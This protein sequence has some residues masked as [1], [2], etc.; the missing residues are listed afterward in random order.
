MALPQFQHFHLPDERLIQY[1]DGELA[2]V[3]REQARTHLE[4]CWKCR[5]RGLELEKAIAG[6]VRVQER[7]LTQAP[8]GGFAMGMAICACVALGL[9]LWLARTGL[10]RH[11]SFAVVSRPVSALTPGAALLVDR[12]AVC[13]ETNP[14]NRAV[15]VALQRKVF[16]QYGIAGADPRAYE[17]DYL[18]TPALGGAEDIH[19]LWPHSYSATVWN[20]KVKDALEERLR[21]MVCDG[22]LELSTAQHDIA[23]DWIAAYQKYFHSE[24]P[25]P[26]HEK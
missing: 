7:G 10:A 18:V 9:G 15:P 2:G 26:G 11:A 20:A 16:E 13:A 3:E 8:R 4:A 17:V 1:A 14:N 6:Y 23:G 24:M 25:L 22:D 12:G 21:S 19:N 5:A